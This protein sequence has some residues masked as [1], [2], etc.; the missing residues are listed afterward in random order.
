M[1]ERARR[2][3]SE[4]VHFFA[5]VVGVNV[6]RRGGVPY[7]AVLPTLMTSKGVTADLASPETAHELSDLSELAER[8]AAL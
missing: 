3:E 2:I 1:N 4:L 6:T 8:I 5:E 7:L